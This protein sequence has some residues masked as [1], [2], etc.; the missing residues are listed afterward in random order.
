MRETDIRRLQEDVR[1]GIRM[2]SSLGLDV[3]EIELP[4]AR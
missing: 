3:S 2:A 4:F 1:D